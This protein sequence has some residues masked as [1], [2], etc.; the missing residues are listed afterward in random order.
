MKLFIK[1]KDGKPFEHPISEDNFRLAFPN[2][3]VNNLPPEFAAFERVERPILGP[4]ELFTLE[5]STYE[6]VDGVYK[7][8]WYKRNMTPEEKAAKQQQVKTYWAQTNGFPSWSFN[9]ETCRFEAP[10]PMPTDGKQYR[11]NEELLSW[12]EIK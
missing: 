10:V 2:I 4:Y 9:E 5:T 12:I 1:I 6:L 11:W 3:D 7:D 8:V